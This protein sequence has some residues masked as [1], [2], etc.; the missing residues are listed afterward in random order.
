MAELGLQLRALA[1]CPEL[2]E[3]VNKPKDFKTYIVFKD[4]R[5]ERMHVR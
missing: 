2:C 1:P 5:Q 3:H 4:H